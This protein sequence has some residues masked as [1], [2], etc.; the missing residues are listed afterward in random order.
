MGENNLTEKEEKEEETHHPKIVDW[1]ETE[2]TVQ[3]PPN[4]KII[5]YEVEVNGE[6][7]CLKCN[8][9]N[10]MRSK[11]CCNCGNRFS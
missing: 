8:T 7:D 10:E 1:E 11:F 9:K 2:I 6:K 3:K 4:D 5:E